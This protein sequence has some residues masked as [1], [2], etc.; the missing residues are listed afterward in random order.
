[1]RPLAASVNGPTRRIRPENYLAPE[2]HL[3]ATASKIDDGTRHVRMTVLIQR[4]RVALRQTENPGYSLGVHEV[5]DI[6]LP[7]HTSPAYKR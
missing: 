1:M 4:H 7:S 6:N 3:A 5:V 2:P